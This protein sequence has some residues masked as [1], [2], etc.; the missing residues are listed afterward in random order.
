MNTK[1][2]ITFLFVLIIGVAIISQ[3]CVEASRVLSSEDFASSNHLATYP[4]VYE[5]AKTTMVCW[6]GRLASGPSP[7]GPGH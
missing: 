4:S 6:L 3:G 2:A 1:Q 5:K 7:R